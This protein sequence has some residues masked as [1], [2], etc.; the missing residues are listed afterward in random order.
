MADDAPFDHGPSHD[1]LGPLN[2]PAWVPQ[3]AIE[4]LTMYQQYNEGTEKPETPVEF[5]QRL[6]H[7]WLPAV[8]MGMIHIALHSVDERIRMAAQKYLMD[9]SMGTPHTADL[10]EAGNAAFKE[11]LEDVLVDGQ[12]VSITSAPEKPGPDNN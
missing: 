2:D 10:P 12:V 8:T 5:S 9:R 1:G 3:K 6:V 7:E 11:L 4:A